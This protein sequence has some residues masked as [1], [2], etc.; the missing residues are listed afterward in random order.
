MCQHIVRVLDKVAREMD[1]TPRERA[2]VT[3]RRVEFAA[4][5][6]LHQGKRAFLAGNHEQAVT[7]LKEANAHLRRRKIGLALV[8]IRLVPRLLLRAYDLR[9][10]FVFGASTR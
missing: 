2:L 9:D 7:L 5:L 4:V 8:L 3:R 1:L 6:S 10:R